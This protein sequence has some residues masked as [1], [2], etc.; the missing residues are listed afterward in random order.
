[1]H[2]HHPHF[3]AR[4]I[5]VALHFRAR[6]AQPGRKPCSDGV[7]RRSYSSARL[8]NSSSASLASAPSRPGCGRACR[9]RR[10]AARRRR[11]A[12]RAARLCVSS[13]RRATA[14]ANSGRSIALRRA[15][16]AATSGRDSTPRQTNRHPRNRIAGCA[17]RSPAQGH[18]P[19]AA[20]RRQRQQVHDRDVLGQHQAVSAG[21]VNVLV[22]ERADDRLKQLAALAHQDQNSRRAARVP[23]PIILRTVRAIRFASFTRGSRFAHGI[24]RRVPAF[25]LARARRAFPAPRLRRCRAACRAAQYAAENRPGPS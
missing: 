2:G 9:R 13:S 23:S 20:A 8:R 11:T 5:H 4:D 6:V 21:D 15:P 1:M 25:D 14:S 10:T 3:V 19:A 17:A 22:L 18:P 16:R 24:E 12:S 7:S